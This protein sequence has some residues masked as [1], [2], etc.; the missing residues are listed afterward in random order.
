MSVVVDTN[1]LAYL[2]LEDEA[3]VEAIHAVL[4]GFDTI[5]APSHW[6]A[7]LLSA[8]WLTV[9]SGRMTADQALVYFRCVRGLVQVEVPVEELHEVALRLALEEDHSPYDTL[10]VALAHREDAP[11]L[12]YDRK[13]I[14][15][16]PEVALRPEDLL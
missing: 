5:L 15:R 16:F 6:Q 9:R 1:V 7:E 12:T 14:E 4:A 11:L 13:L 10:F 8:F 2:V 3:H